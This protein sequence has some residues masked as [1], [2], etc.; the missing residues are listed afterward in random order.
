M[1]VFQAL[2]EDV[3]RQTEREQQLQRRYGE[4]L[5]ERDNLKHS[6]SSE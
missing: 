2:E 4:L 6:T 5:V 3:Q 1:T